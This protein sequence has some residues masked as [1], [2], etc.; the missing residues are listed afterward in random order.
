MEFLDFM[1]KGNYK[2]F[3]QDLKVIGKKKGKSPTIM[4]IDAAVSSI[5][6]GSRTIG[7]SQLQIL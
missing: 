5:L 1:L 2:K 6:Y 7:L 4:F 3:Y